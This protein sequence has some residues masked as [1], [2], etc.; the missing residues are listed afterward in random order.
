MAGAGEQR[1]RRPR[2]P[3]P[4]QEPAARPRPLRASKVAR[5][6]LE[7]VGELIGKDPEGAT[8]VQR[9]EHGWLVGVEVV[10]IRRVPATA[11]ILAVYEAELDEHGELVGYRRTARYPRGQGE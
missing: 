7:Q 11:D 5:L 9:A 10:E 2:R 1:D 8:S 6:A 3:P 4:E